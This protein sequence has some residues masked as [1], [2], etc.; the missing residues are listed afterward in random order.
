MTTTAIQSAY[1]LL[2]ESIMYYEGRPVGTVAALDPTGPAAKNY[3]ECFVRDFVISALVFLNKGEPEI[4]RNFLETVLQIRT[5]ERAMTG[6]EIQPG[7]MP[8]S[9]RVVADA[10]GNESL[11]AD[12]GERAIGRVAPVDSMMW[13]VIL[14]DT[15]VRVTGD[16]ELAERRDFQRAIHQILQLCLRDTFEVFPALLVPD[17]AFLIDRR[18]G[19]Y[20]HPLEIQSLFYGMLQAAQDLL[21]P[22]PE[23]VKLVKMAIKRKQALRTYVRIF[24]WLDLARLNEIHRFGTEEFGAGSVNMLNIY[25]QSIP[26]WVEHWLPERGGYF[27]GNLGPGRMDFRFFALG[28]L[29]AILFGLATGDQTDDVMALYESRWADLIGN[30]PVKL[31]YP[32]LEGI[33]WELLTGSD[34]KNVPWSYHN[35]GNWPCLLWTFVA[36]A[37]KGQRHELAHKAFERACA[38]LPGDSWPEYYDGRTGRLIGRRANLNQTWSAAALIFAD[39]LLQDEKGLA[40]FP[41]E[42]GP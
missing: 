20:G 17:G 26:G 28:N 33:E 27:V 25:P 37:I 36:A 34:P 3:E 29:L 4:V 41:R 8:A 14:L 7:V 23:N 39:Q 19:V 12:F 11:L 38:Q 13:W 31:C 40:M 32:A 1:T 24:Y 15:Y 9:F 2:N 6:H 16:E 22:T 35:G 18:M 30:M 42:P 10:H 5:Q 21:R